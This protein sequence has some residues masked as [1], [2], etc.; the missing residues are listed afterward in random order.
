MQ[1]VDARAVFRDRGPAPRAAQSAGGLG[2]VEGEG[3]DCGGCGGECGKQVAAEGDG[4]VAGERKEVR[5][6][7]EDVG[8][9][10]VHFPDPAVADEAL[11]THE[12][13]HLCPGHDSAASRGVNDLVVGE[14]VAAV[15][16]QDLVLLPATADA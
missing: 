6:A 1:H 3:A 13:R 16:E 9:V 8:D 2:E 10:G 7:L 4:R 15:E 11:F 12:E 5:R 14:E